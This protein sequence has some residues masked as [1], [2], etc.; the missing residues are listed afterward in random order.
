M[1]QEVE[2]NGRPVL[3][4]TYAHLI[5]TAVIAAL[6]VVTLLVGFDLG[7]GNFSAPG[8]GLWPV[9]ASSGGLLV[10][11]ILLVMT[12]LGLNKVA[13][14]SLLFSDVSWFRV[15]IF[16]CS[17]LAFLAL[18]PM[19]GFVFAAIPVAFLLLK[20]AGQAPWISSIVTAVIAPLALYYI[21]SEILNVRI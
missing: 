10:S 17:M 8:S 6:F 21:F 11:I 16:V 4:N 1:E 13:P 3:R 9:L 14:S 18:Y 12:V 5:A 7:V 15:G 20:H 19:V 2:L